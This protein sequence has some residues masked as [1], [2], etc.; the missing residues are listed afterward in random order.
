MI[1]EVRASSDPRFTQLL[2]LFHQEFPPETREPDEELIAEVEGRA[3]L[4]YRYF[5]WQTT[6]VDGFVRFVRL[7]KTDVLFVI[8]I[9][10]SPGARG[11]GVGTRLLE[12]VKAT[13]P[14]LPIVCEVDPHEAMAWWRAR[15]ARPISTSYTQPALRQETEPVAFHL[16]AIGDVGN[17]VQFVSK[18]YEEVWSIPG[19]HAYLRQCVLGIVE[20]EEEK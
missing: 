15:G 20:E 9:A 13:A 4:P 5:V 14:G 2:A 19:D 18:F 17:R 3:P 6:G 10:V 12:A 8:H 11:G 16:M 7:P 1:A